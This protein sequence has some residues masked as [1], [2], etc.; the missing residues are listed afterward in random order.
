MDITRR[1]ILNLTLVVIGV[2][3]LWYSS[4]VLA[5]ISAALVLAL[6]LSPLNQLMRKVKVKGVGISKGL[7]AGLSMLL[8]VGLIVLVTNIFVPVISREIKL[9]SSVK[10][11]EFYDV[12][13]PEIL[14]IK[15]VF[16]SEVLERT[17][18]KSEKEVIKNFLLGKKNL[19][20]VPSFF[21]GIASGIGGSIIALFS[22]FFITFFLLKD[23]ELFNGFVYSFSDDENVDKVK[24]VLGKI[25]ITLS[26]YFIGIVIQVSVITFLVSIGLSVLGIRNALV[27]GLFAGLMNVIPYVGPIIGLAFGLLIGV[28]T[29]I[30]LVSQI[31]FWSLIGE[32]LLVFGITQAVDNFVTQPVVFSKS[33]NAHP[34]EIFLVILVA[35]NLG[36]IPWMIIAVPF[37]SVIRIIAKEYYGDSKFVRFMTQTME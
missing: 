7:S 1:K 13:E 15:N 10:M 17:G 36:G 37:Y 33:I 28:S 30:E 14:S 22:V 23:D 2:A 34:L 20:R 18:E 35:G 9:L 32:I 21:T 8:V 19:D 3:I 31:G 25:K 12:L 27:I 24:T 16:S 11:D 5:Y 4:I 6:I 29:N 26:R